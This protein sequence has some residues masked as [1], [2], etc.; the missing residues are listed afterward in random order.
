MVEPLM[1]TPMAMRTSYGR[2]GLGAE[3]EEELLGVEG[4]AGEMRVKREV[5]DA[6]EER[7]SVAVPRRVVEERVFEPS[8]ML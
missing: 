5:E 3:E 8:M 4:E 1:R 2:V 7:R 6:E